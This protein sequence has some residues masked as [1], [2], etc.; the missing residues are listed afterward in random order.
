[1][2]NILITFAGDSKATSR[3]GTTEGAPRND[4]ASGVGE[5]VNNDLLERC[6]NR[7]QSGELSYD[8]ALMSMAES[9]INLLT[10]CTAIGQIQYYT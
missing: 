1:M 5:W 8:Q 4:A 6:V 9:M 10:N 7:T 3:G 2:Y